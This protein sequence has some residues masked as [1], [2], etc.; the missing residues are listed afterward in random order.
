MYNMICSFS[1]LLSVDA[2]DFPCYY[3]ELQLL[4]A[5][6]ICMSRYGGWE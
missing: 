1:E 6:H 2:S 4:E 5:S 3:D